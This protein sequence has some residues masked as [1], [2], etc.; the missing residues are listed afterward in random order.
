MNIP[1]HASSYFSQL[2]QASLGG[3][4]FGVL[5]ADGRFGRRKAIHEYPF[6]DTS[7]AEDIGKATRRFNILGFLIENSAIY[8]GGDVITQHNNLIAAAESSKPVTLIHPT[9]GILDISVLE[10]SVIE[11]WD[12]GRYF[13]INFSCIESGKRVF[14]TVATS[15]GN[16][17]TAN[18]L[19]ASLSVAADFALGVV[20]FI[21][22]ASSLIVMMS[23]TV[24]MW[25][26]IAQ[27]VTN[28]ATNLFG[29]VASLVGG[30]TNYGR[31]VGGAQAGF[32]PVKSGNIS[33]TITSLISTGSS[34][35][36]AV[37]EAITNLNSIVADGISS[38]SDTASTDATNIADA[39]Q[40]L[41]DAV[42]AAIVNPAD[43]LRL[44]SSLAAFNPDIYYDTSSV[45]GQ[46]QEDMQTI[47]SNLFRRCA[48][49]TL[50]KASENYQPT[51]A[52]D[53]ITVRNNIVAL[54]D[55]EILIAG[56]NGDDDSF[57]A[58]RALRY[59]VVTDLNTRGAALPNLETFTFQAS[60]PAPAISLRLYRDAS[61]ADEIVSETGAPHP[62]F[63]PFQMSLL[64]S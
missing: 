14:P 54:L 16:T 8:G 28:D 40:A 30:Q 57:G 58:L 64:S 26:K 19:T 47:M 15:T 25:G 17:V 52:D 63:Q 60:L 38:D 56:N 43:G 39:A 49:I 5:T 46:A 45:I 33:S 55:N 23:S 44:L 22:Q 4:P 61:R 7:W 2:Q 21:H 36:A 18:A 41:S 13:E 50:A 35:R 24:N 59:A 31:Y 29:M 27:N 32:N 51:S 42:M 9:Y 48:V 1:S 10:I 6:R 34:S 11:K 53:A 3:V 20:K 37:S 12:T 62:M